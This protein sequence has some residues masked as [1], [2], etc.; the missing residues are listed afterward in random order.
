[1]PSGRRPVIV[2]DE[3][4]LGTLRGIIKEAGLSV[5][6]FVRFLND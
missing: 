5:E 1:M 3:I 6:Q 2:P 4:K